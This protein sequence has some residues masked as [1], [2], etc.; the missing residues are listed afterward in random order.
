MPVMDGLDAIRRL[1]QL[2]GLQKT[3]VICVSASVSKE[4]QIEIIRAGCDAFLPK[5]IRWTSLVTEL[6]K[7]LPIQWQYEDMDD[8]PAEDTEIDI[9]LPPRADLAALNEL[10]QRGQITRIEAWAEQLAGRDPRYRALAGQMGQLAREFKITRI[11]R[12]TR[13]YLAQINNH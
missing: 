11:T 5:P 13:K 9:V 4:D 7:H 1:R 6:E 10:V 8:A 12:L 2:P 3:P